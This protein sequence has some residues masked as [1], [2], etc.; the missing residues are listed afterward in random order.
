[1]PKAAFPLVSCAGFGVQGRL[2]IYDA[3][4]LLTNSDHE[5]EVIC[6]E[7][8]A[9]AQSARLSAG[10]ELYQSGRECS[11]SVDI[12]AERDTLLSKD[13]IA[14]GGSDVPDAPRYS[15]LHL[16]HVVAA[17]SVGHAAWNHSA[18]LRYAAQ[19]L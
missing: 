5:F 4:V 2:L 1:M 10:G 8:A 11:G 15:L 17:I 9:V 19:F 7:D 12:D 14:V 18:A 3:V 13:D 16:L 6:L